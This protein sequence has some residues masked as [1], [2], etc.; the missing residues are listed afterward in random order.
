MERNVWPQRFERCHAAKM[1]AISFSHPNIATTPVK[2]S[3]SV[4]G[5][6]MVLSK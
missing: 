4:I 2:Q 3:N 6:E 5:T 1:E